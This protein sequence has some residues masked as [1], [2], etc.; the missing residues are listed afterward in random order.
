L[1]D[2]LETLTRSAPAG[3]APGALTATVVETLPS[4]APSAVAPMFAAPDRFAAIPTESFAGNVGTLLGGEPFENPLAPFAGAIADRGDFSSLPVSVAGL[5]QLG[6]GDVL[7][8]LGAYQTFS[9]DAVN[10]S[11]MAVFAETATLPALLLAA[12]A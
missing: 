11:V 1:G 2:G 12:R 4:D 9:P 7:Q 5:A 6:V 8:T 3:S 10:T